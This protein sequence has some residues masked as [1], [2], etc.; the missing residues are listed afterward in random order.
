MLKEMFTSRLGLDSAEIDFIDR[1]MGLSI[2][3]MIVD[4]SLKT[5]EDVRKFV[6]RNASENHFTTIENAKILFQLDKAQYK[7]TKS[8]HHYQSFTVFHETKDK[9]EANDPNIKANFNAISFN[10]LL[11]LIELASIPEVNNLFSVSIAACEK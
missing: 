3:R 4:G 6:N 1:D 11:F 7:T 10:S 9:K 5:A 8:S 2:A